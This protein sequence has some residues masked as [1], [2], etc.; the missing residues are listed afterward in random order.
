MNQKYIEKAY[1][2]R[3]IIY[4]NELIES[5]R[6]FEENLEQKKEGDV[7]QKTLEAQ[8]R[9]LVQKQMEKAKKTT[10]LQARKEIA[11]KK[12]KFGTK[13]IPLEFRNP[14]NAV[15]CISVVFDYTEQ[16]KIYPEPIVFVWVSFPA[17]EPGN[18]V[19]PHDEWFRSMGK[20]AI[21]DLEIYT[22]KGYEWIPITVVDPGKI[23]KVHRDTFVDQIIKAREE[24][25][26]KAKDFK[27]TCRTQNMK[28]KTTSFDVEKDEKTGQL[29][30]KI[31]KR[32]KD[33]ETKEVIEYDEK[34]EEEQRMKEVTG[35]SEN[36]DSL[37]EKIEQ[38]E[39]S[40]QSPESQ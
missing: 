37:I 2:E 16:G 11:Q 15:V 33:Y 36:I 10:R 29:V 7:K 13:S 35:Y 40:E 24:E 6:Q 8:R 4:T 25:D 18:D 27:Q 19:V 14:N 31:K 38:Y 21:V 39:Q 1:E 12:G 30:G 26:K 23:K 34:A 32:V 5:R 17:P 28:M 20:H 9:V 22:V 3:M